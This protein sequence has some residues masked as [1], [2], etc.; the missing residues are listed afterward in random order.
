MLVSH[1]AGRPEPG[2]DISRLR[3]LEIGSG[4]FKF[5][6]P[7]RTTCLWTNTRLPNDFCDID[8]FSTP[9]RVLRELRAA[10]AGRYDV[11]IAN[12]VRY[13]PW[14][15]RYWARAPFNTPTHPWASIS[16]QFGVSVLR[17]ATIPVPLIAIDMDDSFGIGSD[18]VFLFDKAKAFFKRE[19]PVDNWQVLHGT[20]HPHLPTLRY[21]NSEKW[22]RRIR[23][24]RPI[25]LPICSYDE[26]WRDAPFPEKTHDIFFSGS[27]SGNST[28]RGA[29]LAELDRL[30]ALGYRIDQPTERLPYDAFMERMSHSWLA[31]SPEGMGWD[32]YR[33]YEAPLMQAV[34]LIN[35]P[36]IVRHAPLL[37]GIHAVYYDVEA[38]GMERAVVAAL[39]DKDRLRGIAIAARDHTFAHHLVKDYCDHILRVAFDQE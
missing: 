38:G 14:H 33:H 11:V 7:E 15:P 25:S 4:Y 22:R 28:V 1:D 24:L 34:P 10:A 18:S 32:C 31:W 21:R 20:I 5:Q 3:I 17:W 37:D 29:G 36:T 19:L 26:R 35:Q 39:A 6:Y 16:R 13:S 8:G 12:T 9:D 27:V 23:K 2:L 30:K